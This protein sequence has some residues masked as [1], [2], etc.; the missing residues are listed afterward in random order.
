MR[1]W[2][3][4]SETRNAS[5][6]ACERDGKRHGKQRMSEHMGGS[7]TVYCI[8][9]VWPALDVYRGIRPLAIGSS[10]DLSLDV[11][12]SGQPERQAQ[13]ALNATWAFNEFMMNN[14]SLLRL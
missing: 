7:P 5:G 8:A 3:K 4:E 11:W 2:E 10:M 9:L 13:L 1:L 14:V 6:M 12:K